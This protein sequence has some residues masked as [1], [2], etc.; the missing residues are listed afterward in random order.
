M[1]IIGYSFIPY[2]KHYLI[3]SI[4]SIQK[5]PPNATLH[6]E[7]FDIEL[8]QYLFQNELTYSVVV[9]TKTQL[10]LANALKATYIITNNPQEDQQ[11]AN[12]YLFDSKLLSFIQ[13]IDQIE[14]LINTNI[15]G[16]IFDSA[17]VTSY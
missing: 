5:T 2:Q 10:I 16:V 11:I 3:N 6:L 14:T 13:T 4:E 15:D 7:E 12:E 1:I 17:I 8:M 9:Q